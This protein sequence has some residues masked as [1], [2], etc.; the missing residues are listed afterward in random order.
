MLFYGLLA[1]NGFLAI[2]LLRA[3]R[4]WLYAVSEDS[5]SLLNVLLDPLDDEQKLARMEA[6]TPKLL[7]SLLRVLFLFILAFIL[8]FSPFLDTEL[9]QS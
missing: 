2:W 7:L 5:L 3:Q 4:A 8:A 9:Q 1:F 6:A